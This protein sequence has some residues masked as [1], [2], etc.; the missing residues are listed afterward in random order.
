MNLDDLELAK[1]PRRKDGSIIG[2]D[3]GPIVLKDKNDGEQVKLK[4]FVYCYEAGEWR[5]WL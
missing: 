2:K 4:W 3:F 1:M 5:F